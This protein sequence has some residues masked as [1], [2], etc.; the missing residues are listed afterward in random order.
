MSNFA[1][2]DARL[3]QFATLR[4]L[5]TSYSLILQGNLK[6]VYSFYYFFKY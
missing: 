2:N 4:S 6:H 1:S 3:L 5:D